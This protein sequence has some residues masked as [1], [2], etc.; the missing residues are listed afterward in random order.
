MFFKYFSRQILFSRTLQDSPVCTSTFQA[1][2]N[3]ELVSVA[4]ET[5]LSL[6]FSETQKTGFFA[7]RPICLVPRYLSSQVIK[8]IDL[9]TSKDI[10]PNQAKKEL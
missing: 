3:P 1:C 10:L 7:S 9:R 8:F 6:A 4:K 5:S 2:A